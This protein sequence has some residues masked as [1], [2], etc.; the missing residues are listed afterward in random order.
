MFVTTEDGYI[1]LTLQADNDPHSGVYEWSKTVND[2]NKTLI[3]ETDK[4]KGFI[5]YKA[6]LATYFL[7]QDKAAVNIF[8][9]LLTNII[10]N[11]TNDITKRS[12]EEDW[13]AAKDAI[14]YRNTKNNIRRVEQKLSVFNMGL[15]NKLV[16][17]AKEVQKL[18]SAFEYYITVDFVFDAVAYNRA[19]RGFDKGFVGKEVGLKVKFFNQERSNHHHFLNEA[20]LSAI[21]ISI[22]FAALLLQ[23]PGRLK[24]LALDDVLIGLDMQNRLPV[25][26]ILKVHFNDYQILFL[27]YDESWFEIVKRRFP[28]D[29][30]K[31]ISFYSWK[32][33]ECEIPLFA[34]H[35][36]YLEMAQEHFNQNDY[37][38][39]VGYLR[40][41]FDSVVKQFCE[42]HLRVLY[43]QDATKVPASEFWNAII[44]GH[45]AGKWPTLPKQLLNDIELYRTFILNPLNHA[46]ITATFKAEIQKS[47]NAIR[48]LEV[49]LNA[50]T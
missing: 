48:A 20:K 11:V 5:D 36:K 15:K 4:T 31:R 32:T 33:D 19:R 12:F 9:L 38:A 41:H 27:T 30:W 21:A 28:G 6:L 13:K 14:P 10:P 3:L 26:D 49:G 46:T 29:D 37:K 44:S 16:E 25:L 7:Q 22:F 43:R 23:P 8:D 1:K 18:L 50:I 45:S 2:T 35:K 24:I 40:T 47:M 39:C 34:D 17:L 42:G